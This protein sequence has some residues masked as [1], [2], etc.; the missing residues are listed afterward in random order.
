MKM[1][2][3]YNWIVI[4]FAVLLILA[5]KPRAATPLWIVG[6]SLQFIIGGI[7]IYRRFLRT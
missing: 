2:A 7:F 5:D 3:L 1:A 6:V 4:L